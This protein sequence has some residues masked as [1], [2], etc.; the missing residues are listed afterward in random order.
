MKRY[1]RY[2]LEGLID[3]FAKGKVSGAKLFIRKI[4]AKVEDIR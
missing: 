2:F 3:G 1:K 4:E